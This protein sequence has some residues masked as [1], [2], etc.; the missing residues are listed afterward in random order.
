MPPT[1]IL[2]SRK[3]SPSWTSPALSSE[4][5]PSWPAV[6]CPMEIRPPWIRSASAWRVSLGLC[7]WRRDHAETRPASP[8]LSDRQ[9][10]RQLLQGWW[11]SVRAGSFRARKPPWS[12][13]RF[14]AICDKSHT[15]M[16]KVGRRSCPAPS[17]PAPRPS[18]RHIAPRR[19]LVVP[20]KIRNSRR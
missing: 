8:A 7:A 20:V 12:L 11:Y 5:T 6:R 4:A 15:G 2:T 19:S 18:P 9:R 16:R 3:T 17:F 14:A 1:R 10:W 13:S